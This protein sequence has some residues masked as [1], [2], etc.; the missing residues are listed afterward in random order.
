MGEEKREE[1]AARKIIHVRSAAI[2]ASQNYFCRVNDHS[3]FEVL[4][5]LR[6]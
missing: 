6:A 4:L 3:G 5:F 2:C 1:A